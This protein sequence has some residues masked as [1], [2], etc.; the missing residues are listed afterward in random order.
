ML[1]K[2]RHVLDIA[3]KNTYSEHNGKETIVR[4]PHIGRESSEAGCLGL[5]AGCGGAPYS[6]G[7]YLKSV[8]R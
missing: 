1:K 6:K 2:L 8:R 3:S 5:K 4:P 7:L